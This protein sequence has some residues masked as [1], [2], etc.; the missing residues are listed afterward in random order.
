M[1]KKHLIAAVIMIAAAFAVYSNTFYASFHFDDIPNIVE[2]PKIKNINNIPEMVTA[3]SRGVTMA[4]FALNYYFGGLNVIGYHIVNISIHAINGVLVYFILYMTFNLPSLR[5]TFGDKSYRLALYA[6]LLFLVHPIQTQSVTY[7]V[8][9]LEILAS[10]FY[11]L[12]LFLFIKGAATE[13]MVKKAVFFGGVV[14]SYILGIYSKE[15]AVTLP[16]VILLYDYYFIADKDVKSVLKR[17]PVY[18]VLA[19]I[20]VAFSLTTISHLGGFGDLSEQSAGFGVKTISPKE[21]LFTQFNVI[22][23]YI[24]LLFLPINQNLDY[25][26]PIAKTLFEFP[27]ILSFIGIIALIAT[28]FVFH[29]SN[30]KVYG[31]RLISFFILWFF[32]ILLPTSSFIPILDVI[33]EHRIYLA[34]VGFAAIFAVVFDR[35]F[36]IIEAK[37]SKSKPA[38]QKG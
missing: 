37:L 32:I 10:L 34:S 27:T 30:I 16:A 18:A 11:L 23:T 7:I 25:D 15:I 35:V 21:Y 24:R 28:A 5:E 33:F 6:S 36:E 22:W 14:V 4:T 13:G 12:A 3:G 38:E 9:R 29:S 26:Y 19:V 20:T 1:T 31:A 2:N 17:A 8:Q